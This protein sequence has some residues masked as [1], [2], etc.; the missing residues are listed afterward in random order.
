[1]I[2]DIFKI[3]IL[4]LYD[5]ETNQGMRGIKH[6]ISE[7]A[8]KHSHEFETEYDVFDVRG[9]AQVPAVEDY[10]LF[11]STGGPGSPLTSEGSKWEA[12]YFNIV[13]GIIAHNAIHEENKKYL[14]LICHSYQLFCRHFNLGKVC[15]RKSTS[16]GIFPMHKTLDGTQIELLEGLQDPFYAVDSRDYQVIEPNYSLIEEMGAQVLC[17]EKY[18][19]HVDLERAVMAVQFSGEIFGTQFHPEADPEGMMNH[20][21]NPDKKK[22][23]VENHGIDKY[24]DMLLHLNDPDKIALTRDTII[25]NFIKKAAYHCMPVY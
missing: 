3:A 25:P 24:E 14:F 4:D 22:V 20:M 17:I 21:L 10:H 11:I 7:F 19:P 18:R 5:G 2:N 15:K 8:E 6:I 16:F 13:D 12:A 1:M 23:I 9:A